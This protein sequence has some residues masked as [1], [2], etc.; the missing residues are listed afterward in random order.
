MSKD[1]AA[2][3]IDEEDRD[4]QTLP[5]TVD[6]INKS[7]GKLIWEWYDKLMKNP[8]SV[9]AFLDPKN[10]A[11]NRFPNML[12]YDK[13]R[14]KIT[15]G[16]DY[17]HA[18]WV[19]GYEHIGRY[20]LCQVPFDQETESD[21]WRMCNQVKPSLI[22]VLCSSLDGQGKKQMK[23]FWPAPKTDKKYG[24][25]LAVRNSYNEP[26][27]DFDSHELYITDT[28]EKAKVEH[29][30]ALMQYRKWVSDEEMPDNL[31]EFRAMMKI[32]FA[33]AEKEGRGEG[34]LLYL[35]PNGCHRCGIL[36]AVDIIIE[37]ISS[38]KKVGV[39]ETV[40][41]IRKQRYGA[42]HRF[43]AYAFVADLLVRHAVS[44]G[45]VDNNFIGLRKT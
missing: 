26:N 6:A 37:R 13:S 2:P 30:V 16:D 41:N 5:E 39:K 42:F 8:P 17:I 33:R 10:V 38:E 11:K 32:A 29:K 31:L 12:L 24:Q 20:I 28:R 45:L 4:A 7:D 44:S 34:P 21:F 23:D 14:V 40:V 3:E 18:S 27:R 35:C 43:E 25:G 19:D 1:A 22:V 9:D 15:G 36:A